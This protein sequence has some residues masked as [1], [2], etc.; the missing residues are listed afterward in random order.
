FCLGTLLAFLL[1]GSEPTDDS[2]TLEQ[3]LGEKR[4]AH[5]KTLPPSVP[6]PIRALVEK[7]TSPNPLHRPGAADTIQVLRSL[8]KQSV[9]PTQALFAISPAAKLLRDTCRTWPAT[10]WT[11]ELEII[12]ASEIPDLIKTVPVPAI[13]INTQGSPAVSSSA[14]EGEA[15]I[16]NDL[17]ANSASR[18]QLGR[19]ARRKNFWSPPIVACFVSGSAA[20]VALLWWI[21]A[22]PATTEVAE[23]ETA[24]KNDTSKQNLE[25]AVVPSQPTGWKQEVVPDDGRLL[26]ESPTVGFPLA[27]DGL[28]NNP[29]GL[30]IVHQDFWKSSA[31]VDSLLRALDGPNPTGYAAAI[32]TWRETYEV[33]QFTRTLIGQYQALD[34]VQHAILLDSETSAEVSLAGWKLVASCEIPVSTATVETGASQEALEEIA[35]KNSTTTAPEDDVNSEI[36]DKTAPGPTENAGKSPEKPAVYHYLLARG[37]GEAIEAA[38]LQ[39]T[40][41]MPA[42]LAEGL[43]T[44]PLDRVDEDTFDP[45]LSDIRIDDRKLP[46]RRILVGTPELVTSAVQ[47]HGQTQFAGTMASLLTFSDAQRHVQLF[48]NPVTI[49][50]AQGQDWLGSRWQWLGQLI[51]DRVPTAVRMMYLSVH[52]VEGG[53]TYVE[54]KVVGDRAQPIGDVLVPVLDDLSTMSESVKRSMLGLPRV[55]YWENALLRYDTM[56]NDVSGL[57]RAGQHDRVPTLNVWLRPHALS[58]LAAATEIY[59]TAM[60]AGG[61][62][63]A[64]VSDQPSTPTSSGPKDLAELLRS[65]LSLSIPEQDLINALV[66]LESE[67]KTTHPELPFQFSIE[68]DGNSLRLDGITQNQ[69]IT[70][71]N[72]QNRPLAE[73][74]TALVLKANPDPAVTSARDPK[75]KLIWLVDPAR[76]DGQIRVTTRGAA[77]EKGWTLPPEV[78]PE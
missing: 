6:G 36:P 65:P 59:F 72:Q 74:L 50:N 15:G 73:I 66:E 64:V 12:K 1:T 32:Q 8:L 16:R 71:F 53:E 45:T 30:L 78:Q 60:S 58:N 42:E 14:T 63:S 28:P 41:P 19:R 39:L 52:V 7:L 31:T 67:I 21:V 26:W 2:V 61:G 4:H 23:R 76:P 22:G 48:I 20:L 13:V 18:N 75:C 11:K 57:V 33:E 49:W 43:A 5:A 68:L 24:V 9:E 56:L 3:K 27:V 10:G 40:A 70:N 44:A 37:E 62:G 46:V 34:R 77:Q 25:E 51:K 55:A 47:N 69:K 35:P 29:S 17:T 54:W 38:W